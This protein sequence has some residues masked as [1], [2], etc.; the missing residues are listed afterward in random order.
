MGWRSLPTQAPCRAAQS[1]TPWSIALLFVARPQLS[2]ILH[3]L[4]SVSSSSSLCQGR[5]PSAAVRPCALLYKRT[6]SE[7]AS[8]D[9]S[10]S[11]TVSNAFI[12]QLLFIFFFFCLAALPPSPWPNMP[13]QYWNIYRYGTAIELCRIVYRCTGWRKNEPQQSNKKYKGNKQRYHKLMIV[14]LID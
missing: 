7:R 5:P 14:Q 10:S 3:P 1:L 9:C 12:P 6:D 4:L 13:P 8:T 2:S 11:S